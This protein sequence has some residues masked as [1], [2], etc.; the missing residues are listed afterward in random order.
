[1]NKGE[2][3]GEERPKAPTATTLWCY[4]CLK[5]VCCCCKCCYNCCGCR[6]SGPPCPFCYFCFPC[7][8]CC[9]RPAGVQKGVD[10]GETVVP[11]DDQGA[12]LELAH[13][14]QEE[15][16]KQA[17]EVEE[18][19][20]AEEVY[21]VA[22]PSEPTKAAAKPKAKPRKQARPAGKKAPKSTPAFFTGKAAGLPPPPKEACT[23]PPP[24]VGE[25]SAPVGMGAY[26]VY[27]DAEGGKL[28][29][30][31]SKT[32][33]TGAGVLAY[34]RPEKEIGD[35]KFEK[36]S[37]TEVHASDCQVAYSHPSAE[38]PIAFL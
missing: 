16:A 24:Q 38:S 31:W 10:E 23:G 1:M 34:L 29:T 11:P 8:C 20:E 9:C 19:E 15:K 32:P 2:S 22:E 26:L 3:L 7:C 30:Q 21:E 25:P 17:E 4:P 27:T 37:A 13:E 6:K 33:L 35:Y 12:A 5:N 18:V 36:K 14:W 28:K